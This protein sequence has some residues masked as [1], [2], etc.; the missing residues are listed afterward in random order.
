MPSWPSTLPQAFEERDFSDELPERLVRSEIEPG[1]EKTRERPERD[2]TAPLSGGMLM[3]IAQWRALLLWHQDDL[4][5]GVLAFDFP[6]PDDD[7]STILV[8]LTAPP[9][10]A[11]HR[12]TDVAVSL[13]FE[14]Q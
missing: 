12:G 1:V 10:L 13:Q 4:F 7:T 2:E 5:D 8:A 9:S 11:P 3:T 6:D 14:R